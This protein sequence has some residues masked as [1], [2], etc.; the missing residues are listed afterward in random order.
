M[1]KFNILLSNYLLA[2]RVGLLKLRAWHDKA[3]PSQENTTLLTSAYVCVHALLQTGA[4]IS[5]RH[6]N[7]QWHFVKI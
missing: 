7:M 1:L 2:Y 5:H 4:G 6:R 3:A